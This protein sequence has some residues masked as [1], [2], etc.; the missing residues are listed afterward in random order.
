MAIKRFLSLIE[1]FLDSQL[2]V[3]NVCKELDF[4]SKQNFAVLL[5]K[6]S[7]WLFNHAVCK[8]GLKSKWEIR[9]VE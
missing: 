4:S 2:N 8:I 9:M 7:A 3:R 1:I 5:F 6:V